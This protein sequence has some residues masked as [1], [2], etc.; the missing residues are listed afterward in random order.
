MGL[1]NMLQMPLICLFKELGHLLVFNVIM[2]L[3]TTGKDKQIGIVARG[4]IMVVVQ[5]LQ[6]CSHHLTGTLKVVIADMQSSQITSRTG[7]RIQIGWIIRIFN[8]YHCLFPEKFGSVYL[9]HAIVSKALPKIALGL[10]QHLGL[11]QTVGQ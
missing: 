7:I 9:H 3:A 4:I 1:G 8:R 2:P 6:S 5:M 10:A 11:S